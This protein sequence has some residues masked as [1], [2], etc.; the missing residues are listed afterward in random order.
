M[1]R[2][3]IYAHIE[4]VYQFDTQ[5]EAEQFMYENRRKNWKFVLSKQT[6]NY[7]IVIVRKPFKGYK[8]TW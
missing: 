5:D 1:S 6:G 4:Y 2:Q 7:Y 8:P 3:V